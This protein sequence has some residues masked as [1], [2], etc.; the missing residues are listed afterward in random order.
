VAR[1]RIEIAGPVGK[2]SGELEEPEGVPRALA[3]VCHPHPLHGGTMRST[4]V[5]RAARALRAAGF[6]TVRVDFRGVE[7]SEGTHDGTAEVEDAAAALAELGAR[8]PG[9]PRWAGGFSFGARIAVDLALGDP[10]IERV[11]L[12]AF[13][14]KI[15]A[16]DGLARLNRRGLLVVA[17]EDRFGN[18]ADLRA[19]LGAVPPQ[20]ELV[21]IPGADHFFRGRTPLVE[22]AVLRYARVALDG[23][24]R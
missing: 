17:A 15:S 18:A 13:P 11:V 1:V 19:R 14:A 23:A 5:V 22:E 21:E 9:L 20:L 16:P 3:V 8:F 7:D 2:L 4:L 10:K 24:A 6:A 12:I